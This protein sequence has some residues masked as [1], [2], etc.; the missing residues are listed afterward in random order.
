[1]QKYQEFTRLDFNFVM[2]VNYFSGTHIYNLTLH[3]Q[4]SKKQHHFIFR[5]ITGDCPK[6]DT[7]LYVTTQ[8]LDLDLKVDVTP[9]IVGSLE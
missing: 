6:T 5:K 2:S 1:M 4:N 3:N 7:Y 8:S 9:A